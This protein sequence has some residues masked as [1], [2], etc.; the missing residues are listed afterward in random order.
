MWAH[1]WKNVNA[2]LNHEHSGRSAQDTFELEQCSKNLRSLP[3]D[4]LKQ[5][6]FLKKRSVMVKMRRTLQDE[7]MQWV[8]KSKKE[9]RMKMR[10]LLKVCKKS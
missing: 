2:C 7:Q 9:S 3:N 4:V 6:M 5:I 1:P 10:Q 8:R